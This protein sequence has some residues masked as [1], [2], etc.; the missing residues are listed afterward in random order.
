MSQATTSRDKQLL[1]E[2]VLFE[3]AQHLITTG[4]FCTAMVEQHSCY[5]TKAGD[6]FEEQTDLAAPLL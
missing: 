1:D 6:G 5:S 3:P 2:A 4:R